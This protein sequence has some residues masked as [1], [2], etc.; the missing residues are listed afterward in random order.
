[1]ILGYIS[2]AG[3]P[4][5]Y[6][7]YRVV[8]ASDATDESKKKAHYVCDGTNDHVEIQQAINDLPDSGGIVYLTE[9]TFN[10][11][12]RISFDKKIWIIG[13]GQETTILNLY[14]LGRAFDCDFLGVKN[15][16][17]VQK[18]GYA[19]FYSPKTA[20]S[21]LFIQDS[22]ISARGFTS[23]FLFCNNVTFGT[24]INATRAVYI[25]NCRGV[26][27]KIAATIQDNEC[28]F[29]SNSHVVFDA[30][31]FKKVYVFIT[32]SNVS[33][34]MSSWSS[35]LSNLNLFI[36]NSKVAGFTWKNINPAIIM[37][38]SSII[39]SD[40]SVLGNTYIINSKVYG[41]VTLNS[42]SSAILNSKVTGN[43][44]ANSGIIGSI[45]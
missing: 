32:N 42:P 25:S 4:K 41:N 22:S 13:S 27:I 43:I 34:G 36:S 14:Q 33:F 6:I 24:K 40:V 16:K 31:P 28:Y 8:A 17:T 29:I 39:T 20:N 11:N 21:W 12:G 45:L 37:I 30:E 1:M 44:I 15:I 3:K 2:P 18:Y 26:K 23:R 35:T 9:G 19:D 7:P 5:Y 10:I 38:D